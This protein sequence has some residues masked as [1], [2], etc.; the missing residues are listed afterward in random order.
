[1]RNLARGALLRCTPTLLQPCN[2]CLA[3]TPPRRNLFDKTG[4]KPSQVGILVV[5]CSLHNPTPSWCAHI[6]NHFKMGSD[7]LSFN[8]GGMGCSGEQPGNRLGSAA[9]NHSP[10]GEGLRAPSTASST[11]VARCCG[12]NPV[13]CRERVPGSSVRNSCVL[14]R[15]WHAAS[16]FG[17]ERHQQSCLC[18]CALQ[19]APSPSTWRGACSCKCQTHTPW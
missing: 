4:V 7:V 10:G 8:L 13:L 18:R 2:T 15:S 11:E 5:N 1:M 12:P 9:C 14:E 6:M 16:M 3:H 19:P 17:A